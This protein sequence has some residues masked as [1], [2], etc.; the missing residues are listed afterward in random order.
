MITAFIA[1]RQSGK[2][3][4][5]LLEFLKEPKNTLFVT[6][7]MDMAKG[8]KEYR[9]YPKNFTSQNALS[10]NGLRGKR[11]KK[12]I[13]DEYCFF[14][15]KSKLNL[16]ER[17]FS[18]LEPNG[19]IYIYS[20][21]QKSYDRE[22]YTLVKQFKSG[23]I[24]YRQRDKLL[25]VWSMCLKRPLNEIRDDFDEL[26]N[27]ILTHPKTEIINNNQF[28]NKTIEN[29]CHLRQIERYGNFFN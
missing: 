9:E 27:D 19:K 23:L 11:Y 8:F 26:V 28:N 13:L 20:S 18:V 10:D 14:S 7:K 29:A 16:N 25:E 21:P 15:P 12:I 1:N 4:L 5:A 17:I 6:C 22:I 3:Q 24:S 2:T